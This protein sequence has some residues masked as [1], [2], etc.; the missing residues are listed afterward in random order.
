MK[1]GGI[2]E[3]DSARLSRAHSNLRL[4]EMLCNRILT[5]VNA[6]AESL[7]IELAQAA[8]ILTFH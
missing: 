7:T 6:C 5:G 4:W 2:A 3:N 1:A 8:T